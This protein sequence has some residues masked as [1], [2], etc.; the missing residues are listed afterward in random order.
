[1]I[2]MK[3]P[4]IIALLI[5]TM[6]IMLIKYAPATLAAATILEFQ[7]EFPTPIIGT[8]FN[9]NVTIF[10]VTN[11]NRWQISI[12]FN[13][14]IINCI[15][16]TIPTE[17]IFMGYS[18][19]FPQPIINNTSGQLIAFCAIDGTQGVSG[20]GTLCSIK[21][22]C[23]NLGVSTL[24]FQNPM[25]LQIGGTYL[26]DPADN[27]IPFETT[28]GVVQAIAQNFIERAFNVTYNSETLQIETLSNTTITNMAYN[29]TTKALTYDATGPDNT[30]G[31]TIIT[32]PQKIMN[33]TVIVISDHTPL[34]TFIK[35]LETL[36]EN[37]TCIFLY[38]THP[39][40]TH[41]IKIFYT[42]AGDITGDTV[43]DI[44]DV[45]LASSSFGTLPGSPNW[46][47]IA[48]IN[49]DEV[50][51]IEDISFISKNYGKYL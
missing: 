3:P 24:K 17:N 4:L 1:M 2:Q 43:V 28:I 35:E 12:S 18:I 7:P 8:V 27:L 26:Q 5:L 33:H 21:F 37:E 39:Q 49:Q 48:D 30:I 9:V 34:R 51:D 40:S 32:I 44:E 16:I 42:I 22:K 36:P 10:N 20:S 46:K 25:R 15:S 11:L 6:S 14:K 41:K 38:Y 50:V 13:P 23:K 31:A 29:K 19:I 47:T 45:A